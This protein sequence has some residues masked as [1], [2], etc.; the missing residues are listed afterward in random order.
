MTDIVVI[1]LLQPE[2]D[3][4]DL[5][6]ECT[7]AM[8]TVGISA[9][10]SAKLNTVSRILIILTMYLGRIGPLTMALALGQKK[11]GSRGQIQYPE[12]NIMIG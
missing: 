2:L 1:S 9:F 5:V 10:G 4:M 8:G 12:G 3:F 7:S 6:M 11:Q